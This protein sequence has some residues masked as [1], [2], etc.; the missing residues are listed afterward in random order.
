MATFNYSGYDNDQVIWPG[1]SPS[2]GDTI[3]FTIPTDHTISI[4]DNDSSLQDGTDDRDDEDSNQTVV[5]TDEF[6]NPEASGQVQPRDQITLTDGTNTYRMTE[7]FIASSNSYYYIFHDPAP[8]LGVEYTVTNVSS[9]NSTSYSAFSNEGVVCFAAE[10]L[11]L[12]P[13]GETSVEN[14][15]KGDLVTTMDHGPRAIR[16]V[17]RRRLT[18]PASPDKHKPIEIKAAALGQGCPKRTLCVSPQ[19]RL[20]ITDTAL[21]NALSLPEALVAAKG[22]LKLRGVRQKM[23]CREV[24]YIHLVFDQHEII[25]AEGC[26]T[27]SFFPGPVA[28]YSVDSGVQ[29][30][31]KE[32]FPGLSAASDAKNSEMARICVGVSKAQRLLQHSKCSPMTQT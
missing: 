22:L 32:I 19:H 13:Q 9:P 2:N 21:S 20:L 23:G 14:L 28:V 27:E 12:T 11:I 15:R 7:I 26:P 31:L 24:E 29:Q 8:E 3:T 30:E 10:T 16:L 4:T 25:F 18:F 6:G 1:G 17:L 5:V